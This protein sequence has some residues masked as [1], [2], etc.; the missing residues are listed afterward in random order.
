MFEVLYRELDRVLALDKAIQAEAAATG[1][2]L[3]MSPKDKGREIARSL[4]REA[5]PA[6]L[7][8]LGPTPEA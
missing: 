4:E 2:A 5:Y 1:V 6:E 7:I 3:A 8:E